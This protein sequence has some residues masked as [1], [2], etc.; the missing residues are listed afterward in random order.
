MVQNV[1]NQESVLN[2]I[3]HDLSKTWWQVLA[4]IGIGGLL[5]F[6]WTIIMRILGGLM[7]W[8]SILMV[9]VGLGAGL[10]SVK[11]MKKDKFRLRLQLVEM[12]QAYGCRSDQ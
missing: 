1:I 2:K 5:A 12:E 7:I 9:L 6:V 11:P 4:L 3:A 10:F 8:A